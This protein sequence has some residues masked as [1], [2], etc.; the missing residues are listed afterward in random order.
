MFVRIV[1]FVILAAFIGCGTTNLNQEPEPEAITAM[2]PS[3][4]KAQVVAEPLIEGLE[5]VTAAPPEPEMRDPE[6][7]P[8]PVIDR[9]FLSRVLGE[10]VDHGNKKKF[11]SWRND[12]GNGMKDPRNLYVVYVYQDVRYTLWHLPNERLSFWER[13][14]GSIELGKV[15]TWSDG[16]LTGCVNFGIG[17]G[18][19][20]YMSWADAE[21]KGLEYH[22]YWQARYVRA[23]QGLAETLG[24]R[25]N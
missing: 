23:I 25:P 18:Q 13:P 17:A 12:Y 2:E 1:L 11:L 7:C 5:M 15:E 14:E 19:E 8:G 21:E 16:G 4:P 6:D 20:Q 9:E 3:I 10:L 22:P 24:V